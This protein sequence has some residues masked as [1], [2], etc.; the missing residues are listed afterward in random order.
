MTYTDFSCG[1]DN[2]RARV[3]YLAAMYYQINLLRKDVTSTVKQK[4]LKISQ[5]NTWMI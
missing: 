3:L 2:V 1:V 4:A 5:F